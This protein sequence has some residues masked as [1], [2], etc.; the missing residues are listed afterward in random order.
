MPT[1]KHL[2]SKDRATDKRN[3]Y[4]FNCFP[5]SLETKANALPKS[6]ATLA[7]LLTLARFL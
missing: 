2:D 4:T 7:W 1:F 3:H 6:I 5:G